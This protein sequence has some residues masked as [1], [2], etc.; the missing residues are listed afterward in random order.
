LSDS[1]P[2]ATQRALN[3][4]RGF[5]SSMHHHLLTSLAKGHPQGVCSQKTPTPR[6]SDQ[7]FSVKVWRCGDKTSPRSSSYLP[8]SG[9]PTS[10][11]VILNPHVL[12]HPCDSGCKS[13][14]MLLW[15]N[16][17]RL[18]KR[19]PVCHPS[20]ESQSNAAPVSPVSIPAERC[21]LVVRR[22]MPVHGI[23]QQSHE[24]LALT[25]RKNCCVCAVRSCRA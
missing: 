10:P 18:T 23:G 3:C 12:H 4:H 22:G 9:T 15:T 16:A 7:N 6:P 24:V 11:H 21:E 19:L 17:P 1:A 13:K 25:C 5:D 14:C 2:F 8:D 20:C